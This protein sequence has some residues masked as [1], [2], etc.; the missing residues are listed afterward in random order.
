MK[1]VCILDF[2]YHNGELWGFWTFSTESNIAS[3]VHFIRNFF[4]LLTHISWILVPNSKIW[5][6]IWKSF[7]WFGK[8]TIFFI[9]LTLSS[10]FCWPPFALLFVSRSVRQTRNL[11]GTLF[12]ANGQSPILFFFEVTFASLSFR[13]LTYKI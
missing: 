6:W 12:R 5:G 8:N 3:E 2:F 9:A 7:F 4:R 11:G 1:I 10:E 13:Q